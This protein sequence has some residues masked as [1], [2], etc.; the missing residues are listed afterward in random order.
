MRWMM[1]AA[2]LIAAT[3]NSL[4]AE[5]PGRD[6][7]KLQAL[8]LTGYNMHPWRPM[9]EVLRQHL[10]ATGRF[11]VRVNEE[12]AGIT[13]ETLHG[14]DVVI[15]NYTNYLGKFGPGFPEHTRQALLEH[16]KSGK[17][18]TAYHAALSSFAEWPEYDRM[19]GGTWREG[20]KHSPYHTYR[21]EFQVKDHPITA[22]L[23]PSFVQSDELNQGLHM[24]KHITVLASGFDD[25]KNCYKNNPGLCGSGKY[26]PV[27]WVSDYNGGRVFTTALGHDMA[28]IN[29][30]G[31]IAT[32]VRGT[33][34]AATGKVTIAPPASL[35]E[36]K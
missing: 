35:V 29:S 36:T 3:A 22:G 15:L 33:E 30:P 2:L 31:F 5:V 34:W 13:R 9:T 8:I 20:S 28:S 7:N 21:V 6:A 23:L 24:Q 17:G 4:C 19:I 14:Y 27:M 12:P 16:L 25:P 10:E 11:E 32:F 18:I 26:E 1:M